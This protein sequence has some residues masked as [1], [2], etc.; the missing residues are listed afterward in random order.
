[1]I[2]E[3]AVDKT[4][5]AAG[6]ALG[7]RAKFCLNLAR[8]FLSGPLK[9]YGFRNDV[10]T[11]F[12]SMN[13]WMADRVEQIEEYEHLFKPFCAFEGKT[14]LELG[15]NRGYLLNAFLQVESFNAIGADID[16]EALGE[17]RASFGNRVQFIEST[18]DSIPLAD[19]SVD[20]IYTIDTVEHLSKPREIFM[21]AYRVL[22][23]G[24][25]FLIHFHPWLGPYGSHLEDII[26]F[27]W[28]QV[29]FS[30]D[31]LLD[32]A[33]NLYDSPDYKVACYYTDPLTGE[34]KPNPYLDKAKWD[35]FLN[36]ITLKQFKRL[37]KELPFE[38]IHSEMIGFSG[39]M[40]PVARHLKKLSQMA[41]PDEFFTKAMFCVLKKP[42]V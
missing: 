28:P 31:T 35:R 38:L 29:F 26:P 1:M 11:R 17:A 41:G 18:P 32:V 5:P 33:S 14:V 4:L 23:P 8:L 6:Q 39:R 15:C 10:N 16:V 7:L 37:V 22:R 40:F 25:T 42:Q 34:K 9:R 3:Y 27:P 21:E 30:M 19:E 24:G 13:E 36:R 12:E 20:A 2:S